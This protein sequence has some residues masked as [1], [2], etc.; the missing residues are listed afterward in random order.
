MTD[1]DI[2]S[3]AVLITGPSRGLGR[4]AALAIAKQ[5]VPLV[6]MG[7]SSAAF[8]EVATLARSTSTSSVEC[9]FADFACLASVKAAVELVRDAIQ[10]GKWQ[11]LRAL[12]ANAGLQFSNRSQRT[13][14]GL[15]TTFAVNVVANHVLIQGLLPCLVDASV[16]VVG[17]GTHFG[18][19]PAT[20]L[21][22]APRWDEPSVLAEPL[23]A[24]VGAGRRAMTGAT[25]DGQRAYSTSKLAVNYLVHEFQRRHGASA[26]FN[27]Y[28]PGLMPGTG[29]ARDLPP[30]KQ[31]AWNKIMPRLVSVV[32]GMA[33]TIESAQG[34]VKLA[35]GQEHADARGEYFEIG[36]ASQ[37]S[38]ESTNQQ[39]ESALWDYCVA[40]SS[41]A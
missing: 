32:P 40:I 20:L 35:L 16:V 7:R 10:S 3:R 37:A 4:E 25:R 23:P 22:A 31:W 18:A 15:E 26:R 6:L 5:N 8:D 19:K 34:L 17:S 14:D 1:T 2:T 29:L 27:V 12:I 41:G 30:V 13:V 11:P 38:S 39:R 21:V 24:V 33:I 9:V 36:V 28:D